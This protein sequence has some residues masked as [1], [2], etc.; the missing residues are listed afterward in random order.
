MSRYRLVATTIVGVLAAI[1]LW[2]AA[3][4]PPGMGYDAEP[5]FD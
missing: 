5:H 3:T 1:T 4:Y 2:N